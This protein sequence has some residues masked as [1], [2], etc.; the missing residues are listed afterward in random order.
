MQE[1]CRAIMAG[2]VFEACSASEMASL[3]CVQN[4]SQCC[5]RLV[6]LLLIRSLKWCRVC[7]GCEGKIMMR[8]TAIPPIATELRLFRYD[9]QQISQRLLQTRIGPW[10]GEI[11][12]GE[13]SLPAG[14]RRV[15]QSRKMKDVRLE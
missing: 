4:I 8:K 12:E 7:L 10:V 2:D 14:F 1:R 9:G 13:I 5:Q 3:Y 15:G 6:E 11:L